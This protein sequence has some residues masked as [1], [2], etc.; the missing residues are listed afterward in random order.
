MGSGIRSVQYLGTSG[1]KLVRVNWSDGRIGFLSVGQAP[2]LPFHVTA[3][4]TRTVFQTTV[5]PSHIYRDLLERC[6]PYLCGIAE[7][8]PL[9]MDQLLEP[10]LS[11]LAARQSWL[12]HGAEMQ[13]KD[14]P[15]DDPGYDGSE[16]ALAYRRARMGN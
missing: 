9:P 6:L 2:P 5:E 7:S 8:P 1:Q 11:A 4:T 16:F 3:V 14:L 12:H 15:L 10:E 13:L